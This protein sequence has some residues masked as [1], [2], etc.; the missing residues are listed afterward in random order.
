MP[1]IQRGLRIKIA[2][3]EAL[4]NMLEPENNRVVRSLS[5]L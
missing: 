1:E 5:Q 4:W 2:G 3:Y